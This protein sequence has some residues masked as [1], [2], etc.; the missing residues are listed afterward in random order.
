MRY[1]MLLLPLIIA[2]LISGTLNAKVPDWVKNFDSSK[3]YPLKLYLTGF[4]IATGELAEATGI[5]Q[6]SARGE[7]SRTIR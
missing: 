7:V 1:K 2:L 5:A 6:E 4:G 3:K